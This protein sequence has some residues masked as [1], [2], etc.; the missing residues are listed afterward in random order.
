MLLVLTLYVL[1][2]LLLLELSLTKN[3]GLVG[4][5]A[6]HLIGTDPLTGDGPAAITHMLWIVEREMAALDQ[7][8]TGVPAGEVDYLVLNENQLFS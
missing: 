3:H 1:N 8:A 6:T 5:R 7:A 4:A 2:L